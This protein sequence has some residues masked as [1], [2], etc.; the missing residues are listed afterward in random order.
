MGM[1]ESDL[2]RRRRARRAAGVTSIEY[3]LIAALAGVALFAAAK[4]LGQTLADVFQK[5][6]DKPFW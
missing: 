4:G 5:L 1:D 6:A 3:A 2:K